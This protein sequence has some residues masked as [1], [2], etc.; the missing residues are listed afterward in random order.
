MVGDYFERHIN[1]MQSERPNKKSLENDV[2]EYY[3]LIDDILGVDAKDDVDDFDDYFDECVSYPQDIAL[4]PLPVGTLYEYVSSTFL[5]GFVNFVFIE[6]AYLLNRYT[7]PTDVFD[8][9]GT[10]VQEPPGSLNWV[11]LA[12]LL[13]PEAN[14]DR[15]IRILFQKGRTHHVDLSNLSDDVLILARV[16][17]WHDGAN[18]SQMYY[19]FWYDMDCSDCFI[20]RFITNDPVERVTELFDQHAKKIN[21]EHWCRPRNLRTL[22]DP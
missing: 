10:T 18:E 11:T 14:R 3:E 21:E 13:G 19:F 1:Y 5:N 20:G 7:N 22:L 17:D 6:R 16:K 8:K 2:N 15:A 4:N 12:D 9:L